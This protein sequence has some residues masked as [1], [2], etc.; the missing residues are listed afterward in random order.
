MDEGG[1]LDKNFF[2]SF[3][4]ASNARGYNWKTQEYYKTFFPL[5][6]L[7]NSSRHHCCQFF[8]GSN[9]NIFVP[10]TS[11]HKSFVGLLSYSTE[12]NLISR[13]VEEVIH[14]FFWSVSSSRFVFLGIFTQ[15]FLFF[16]LTHC[17]IWILQLISVPPQR[18]QS[19]YM[20]LMICV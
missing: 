12:L 18:V 15:Y 1:I 14:L 16:L 9:Y 3:A 4:D 20:K 17:L 19:Q 11:S 2:S 8:Q 6:E 7:Y 13:S 10:S 5:R